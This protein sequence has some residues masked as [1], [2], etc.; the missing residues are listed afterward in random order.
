MSGPLP[1][2]AS[3]GSSGASIPPVEPIETEFLDLKLEFV[4]NLSYDDLVDPSASNAVIPDSKSLDGLITRL[5]KLNDIIE[6]RCQWCDKGMRL[7]AMQRKNHVDGVGSD[8][9]SERVGEQEGGKG[10][11]K[12]R[13]ANDSLAPKDINTG[14]LFSFPAH[15][16]FL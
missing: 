10:N 7:V 14:M 8:G 3:S 13:K 11:K 9:K 4:R 5:T 2:P 12:K 15:L 6:R 1:H 16:F